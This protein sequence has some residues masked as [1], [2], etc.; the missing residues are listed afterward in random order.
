MCI[1]GKGG[2]GREKGG[3]RGVGRSGAGQSRREGATRNSPGH[4]K[5]LVKVDT[6]VRVFTEGKEGLQNAGV[7]DGRS[8][9]GREGGCNEEL[10]WTYQVVGRDLHLCMC[11]YGKSSSSSSQQLQPCPGPPGN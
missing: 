3:G 2:E 4:V 8:R 11:I 5:E 9:A 10:T 6:S 1:Y 7:E